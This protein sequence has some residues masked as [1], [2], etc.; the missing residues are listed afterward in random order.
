MNTSVVR[1]NWPCSSGDR[2]FRGPVA[3]TSLRDKRA[4]VV[5]HR[6]QGRGKEGRQQTDHRPLEATEVNLGLILIAV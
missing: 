4:S 2:E 5:K 3:G 6:K 1:R